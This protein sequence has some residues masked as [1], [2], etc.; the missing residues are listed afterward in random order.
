[1][2]RDGA[3]AQIRKACNAI[4][5]ELMKINPA[6]VDV[7]NK[8]IKV[9]KIV[10]VSKDT[11]DQRGPLTGSP[12]AHSAESRISPPST[13]ALLRRLIFIPSGLLKEVEATLSRARF[14]NKRPKHLQ[15]PGNNHRGKDPHQSTAFGSALWLLL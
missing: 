14:R 4:S 2:D 13:D 11:I 8:R 1:M 5:V 9:Q 6:V 15:N 10:I 3:I 7:D 12:D